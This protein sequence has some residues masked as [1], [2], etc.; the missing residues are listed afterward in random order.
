MSNAE[1]IR[2][3]ARGPMD[4]LELSHRVYPEAVVEFIEQHG[5][6]FMRAIA[7][8]WRVADPQNRAKIETT[9]AAEWAKHREAMKPQR[10]V[11]V[12]GIE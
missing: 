3:T 10:S 9:W 4:S 11:W 2:R 1:R 8:A 6:S 7:A 5:G 12:K